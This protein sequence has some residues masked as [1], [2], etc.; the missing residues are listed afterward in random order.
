MS[1]AP[2]LAAPS[3]AAPAQ[4]P[5]AQAPATAPAAPAAPPAATPPAAP[6]DPWSGLDDAAK[7]LV[8]AK[9]WKG[10]PDV[11]ASYREL[12]QAQL[13][14]NGRKI[15]LPEKPDDAE[16]W[17][18]IYDRL[19]RPA[20]PD[21]YKFEG[22]EPP[23]DGSLDRVAGFRE[24]FHKAGLTQAQAEALYKA[25]LE[26][27]DTATKQ[28]E[29]RFQASATAEM[30]SLRGTW[31]AAAD[32]NLIAGRMLTSLLGWDE[33]TLE[34]IERAI[35][36]KPMVEA[37]VKVGRMLGE[38]KPVPGGSESRGSEPFG[39]TPDAAKARIQQKMS[40]R[41]FAKRYFSGEETARKEMEDLHKIAAG[42]QAVPATVPPGY[43][44]SR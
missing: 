9:G 4:S 8:Q 33:P 44:T 6:A 13:T 39:L 7:G 35:G 12:E 23:T 26:M 2:E 36:T 41:D 17:G 43:V 30:E 10:L 20:K 24:V 37:L 15:V 14:P 32:E 28:F 38:G 27:F 3:S 25:D 16:G 31:G 22:Y 1:A 21:A 11:F 40:D 42:E 19:G 18:K 29:E 5:A 34:K